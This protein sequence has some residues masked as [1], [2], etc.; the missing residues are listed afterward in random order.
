MSD[1]AY[2]RANKLCVRY[3]A[4]QVLWDVDVAVEKGQI[5]A[6]IGSN[7][8][9]KST[10]MDTLAG[11]LHSF[12]GSIF[13]EENELTGK[14]CYD[15]IKQGII[16]CPEGRQLFP[17][18]TV[19]ENLELG[20]C[21]KEAKLKKKMSLE[22]VFSWFPILSERKSQAAGTLSGGEQQMVAFSRGLMGLPKVLLM[23]EPS[24]GLAPK[25]VDNIFTIAKNITKQD[26]LSIV[27]A[28]QDARKALNLASKGYVLENGIISL[29]GTSESLLNDENV[30]KAYLGF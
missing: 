14:S 4:T 18:M 6:L 28:E 17:E 1:N 20:A 25:I 30:K 2:L 29:V 10:T 13:F 19:Q 24:L 3:G 23:D 16:L 22:K 8:A 12:S 5:I 7:G 9:G 11:L 21:T 15:F 27:L 26:G